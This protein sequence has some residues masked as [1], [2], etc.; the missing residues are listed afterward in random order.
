MFTLQEL[1]QEVRT[2]FRRCET[3][4]AEASQLRRR[5]RFEIRYNINAIFKHKQ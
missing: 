5:T 2:K 3:L 1:R 4:T